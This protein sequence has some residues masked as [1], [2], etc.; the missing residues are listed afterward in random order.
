MKKLGFLVLGVL[1]VFTIFISTSVLIA[2]DRVTT[3]EEKALI[4]DLS[5][6]RLDLVKSNSV[7]LIL[8]FD[9]KPKNYKN[10]I[11]SLDGELIYDYKNIKAMA[12]KIPKKNIQKLDK[13]NG[14]KKIKRD[15]KVKALLD[16]SV[17]Q[18]RADDVQDLGIDGT[19]VKIAVIDSGIDYNHPQFSSRINRFNSS[20]CY[21]FLNQ[22]DSGVGCLDDIGHG[23]HVSGIIASQHEIYKGVAPG[24]TLLEYKV[25]NSVGEGYDSDVISAVDYA[26]SNQADI[27]SLSIGA[28]VDPNDPNCGNPE[29]N[30]ICYCYQT[31]ISES[32]DDAVVNHS[33]VVIAASGNEGTIGYL[34]APACADEVISVGAVDDSDIRADFSDG[35]PD[36]DLVAP[37]MDIVSTWYGND[38]L[39]GG[40]PDCWK[41]AEGTSMSTPHV[42]GVAALMLQANPI[43]TPQEVRNNLRATADDLGAAGRDDYYGW[44]RVN[45]YNA[46]QAVA[47]PIPRN[48]NIS[49]FS[50]SSYLK[51]TKFFDKND[52]VYLETYVTD[53]E[54]DPISGATVVAEL[55]NN[56]SLVET[57]LL[58]EVGSGIYRGSFASSSSPTGSY[59]IKINA[60][61]IYG[62]ST[63][64][65][66]F[67]VYPNSGVSAYEID[68]ING[69][70][71]I[72]ENKHL[73]AG[74]N[75]NTISPISYLKQKDKDIDYNFLESSCTGVTNRG[76]I[77]NGNPAL[78][79]V[80]F[81]SLGE[82]LQTSNIQF[83]LFKISGGGYNPSLNSTPKT[84][85]DTWGQSCNGCTNNVMDSCYSSCSTEYV[86][87]VSVNGSV[88]APG[89]TVEVTMNYHCDVDF[90]S[91][92]TISISY[93]NG[94]G[95]INKYF[96]SFL[97]ACP[98]GGD[99]TKKINL[100]LSENPGVHY[101]RGSISFGMGAPFTCVE[102]TSGD[103]DDV[104]LIVSSFSQQI[105]K[106]G[107]L[108]ITLRD[109]DDD[110]LLYTL[111][112]FT[113][114]FPS[115]FF[116]D[117]TGR[118]GSSIN[119]DRYHIG[120]GSDDL[121]T[122]LP[123]NNWTDYLTNEKK[124]SAI[125]DITENITLS[126]VHFNNTEN[127]SFK[128]V[129]LW[130]ETQKQGS[131][132]SYNSSFLKPTD[133][134]NYLL[135]FTKGN[136]SVIE[137]KMSIINSEE[138]PNPNFMED[139]FY[140]ENITISL[141]QN[142]NL[143][144]IPLT[145]QNNSIENVFSSIMNK[146][147]VINGFESGVG[148]GAK[149]Y[150][151]LLPEFSDLHNIDYSHG[152]WVKMNQSANLAV[153]GT[154]PINKTI[155]LLNGWNLI[156]YLCNSNKNVTEVFG[157]IMNKVIVINGFESGVGGGART[158]DPQLPEFSDLQ[159]LKPNYGYWVKM[160]QSA[161]LNY[162]SVC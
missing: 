96:E 136:Y 15:G 32:L 155:N 159:E 61:N 75:L 107:D 120:D 162:N 48:L 125:Y 72:L 73:I 82:N 109:E 44:G 17:P 47:F 14:L 137:N 147:I 5:D 45:A 111:N 152:Y 23:T 130:Y 106:S 43:L 76:G 135:V 53:P 58:T 19:G 108:I 93:N 99:K 116:S 57:I 41:S 123:S 2:E 78:M 3:T 77:S 11:Q 28:I 35:G 90:Y 31:P 54:K 128:N 105:N 143:I 16:V 154:N 64:E 156:S 153:N 83:R 98:S 158:Y 34:N 91:L 146:V 134:I 139:S 52:N 118:I 110:Y 127:I 8:F 100:Q 21:Y 10:F 13:F 33:V 81:N 124:Y 148:G 7:K 12:V 112:N 29:G 1:L 38:P 104:S 86:K 121:I 103:N 37:G 132:I 25:L 30:V 142:W 115:S 49:T 6:L 87:E 22:G 114:S 18:I 129:G 46:Y 89:D 95:W 94:F 74:F 149:T 140:L 126:W 92:N 27:I 4:N 160:N 71:I 36:L 62:S 141:K 84:C 24:V 117:I 85:S 67:H 70:N 56:E 113:N 133:K 88:F 39:C 69:K 80:S 68:G 145:L 20:Q 122:N 40:D 144:S 131:R 151:P 65:D 157:S 119:N 102:G 79:N 50:D 101:I 150:D 55:F 161:V 26:I 60:T 42:S 66:E 51:E 63:E 59:S 9:E 138:F 97:T